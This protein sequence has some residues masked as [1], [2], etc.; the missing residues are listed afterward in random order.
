MGLI[1]T[2]QSGRQISLTITMEKKIELK[3]GTNGKMNF[4]MMILIKKTVYKKPESVNFAGVSNIIYIVL[5]FDVLSTHIFA[6]YHINIL[7]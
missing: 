1:L 2:I 6:L 3:Y 7:A 4:G 5:F